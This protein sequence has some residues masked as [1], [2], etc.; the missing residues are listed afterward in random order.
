[1]DCRWH[2]MTGHVMLMN[3][4]FGSAS[5]TIRSVIQGLLVPCPKEFLLKMTKGSQ[6]RD[7][8]DVVTTGIARVSDV[9]KISIGENE[10][11]VPHPARYPVRFAEHLIKTFSPNNGTVLDPFVGSGSTL[12]AAKKHRR[13]YIGFDLVP[14]YVELAIK[15]I[16]KQKVDLPVAFVNDKDNGIHGCMIQKLAYKVFTF[17]FEISHDNLR[18]LLR[19]KGKA[20]SSWC[21]EF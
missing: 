19:A 12:I 9:I 16:N 14:E 5:P 6:W 20:L 8:K 21:H 10:P 15:R 4:F 2:A 11:N 1:M 18:C 3:K 17:R 7:R 13:K